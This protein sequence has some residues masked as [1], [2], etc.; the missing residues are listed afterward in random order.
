M[1]S[2]T[3]ENKLLLALSKIILT[4]EDIINIETLIFSIN[5][6]NNILRFSIMLGVGAL[7][8]RHM[9]HHNHSSVIPKLILAEFDK[10]YYRSLSRNIILYEHYQ[11][12]QQAFTADKIEIIP[13]KGIFLAETLYID[14]GLRQMSDIDLLVKHEDLEKSIQILMNLGYKAV[15]R[16]KTD[17]IKNLG[18]EKHLPTM[19][20]NDIFVEI[21]YRIFID[22]SKYTI[23]IENYWMNSR[24]LILHNTSTLSLSPENLLQYLCIHL[25]RHFNEGKIQ[26]YQFADLMGILKK[27][28]KD[29]DWDVFIDSCEKNHCNKNVFRVLYLLH[30]Y[31]QVSFPEKIQQITSQYGSIF[32]ENLFVSY[33]NCQKKE[34]IAQIENQNLK[35]LRKI[36]G[37]KN[38]I[39]YLLG[40]IFP[41]KE[42]MVSRYNIKSNSTTFGF[43]FF[44]LY[45]G[46]T[47]F[48]RYIFKR[49][50]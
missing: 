45:K 28:E 11:N 14:I 2:L 3:S 18:D 22:D 50:F 49:I 17:F 9:Y 30:K 32:I 38:K 20:L 1:E 25:E 37:V 34:I 46:I 43:Y 13:L 23:D 24:P 42:F 4:E 33:L 48:V 21:H 6:W 40:D 41:S 31:F 39:F 10:L 47:I 15:R 26:L 35:N 29:F 44:R 27:H 12:I 5:N 8:S 7:I 19:V 16:Y 36:R